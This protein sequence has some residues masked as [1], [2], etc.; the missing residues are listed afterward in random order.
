[1]NYIEIVMASKHDKRKIKATINGKEEI[2]YWELERLRLQTIDFYDWYLSNRYTDLAIAQAEFEFI[3]EE[4][5][6]RKWI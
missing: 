5:G 6:K 1:M 4:E 2:L 3:D